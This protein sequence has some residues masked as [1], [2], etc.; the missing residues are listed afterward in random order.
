MPK[1]SGRCTKQETQ[2]WDKNAEG[3]DKFR[4]ARWNDFALLVP[5]RTFYDA[6]GDAFDAEGV[7]YVLCTRRD[8]FNRGETADLVNFI[9]LLADPADPSYLAGWIASPLSGFPPHMAG[10]LMAE[11]LNLREGKEPVTAFK[12]HQ[13][14]ISRGPCVT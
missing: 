2:I 8:Y 9:S 12:D 4:P 10:E 6:I 1:R 5:K 3:D 13:G 7:P 11:G 14:E